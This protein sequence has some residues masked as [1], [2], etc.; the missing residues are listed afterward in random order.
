MS[1]PG[2]FAS[3]YAKVSVGLPFYAPRVGLSGVTLY[4]MS[5]PRR[6]GLLL[7][8]LAR[9]VIVDH[10]A[11]RAAYLAPGRHGPAGQ[12]DTLDYLLVRDR[13]VLAAVSSRGR[14][15]CNRELPPGRGGFALA[16]LLPALRQLSAKRA[17]AALA[18]T[19]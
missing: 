4:V 10:D 2:N 14:L 15:R 12:L 19:N 18:H 1:Q 9:A 3:C 6:H 17:A 13:R 5:D 7:D 16:K 8:T 11:L